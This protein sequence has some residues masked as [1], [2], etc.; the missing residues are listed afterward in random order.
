M[1]ASEFSN[2]LLAVLASE[3][4]L[5]DWLA[6]LRDALGRRPLSAADALLIGVVLAKSRSVE[7]VETVLEV[8][9]V[10]K[11]AI[12]RKM[13][14][15]IALR[16]AASLAV[17]LVAS[18]SKKEKPAKKRAKTKAMAGKDDARLS[19]YVRDALPALVAALLSFRSPK[20][21]ALAEESI[22]F[23]V[24]A[25]P[26][27]SP[28]A[29]DSCDIVDAHV[30]DVVMP[31][32]ESLM[33][34]SL[35]A[36]RTSTEKIHE[37]E[38]TT[39]GESRHAGDGVA[40]HVFATALRSIPEATLAMDG[41]WRLLLDSLP[42]RYGGH[43][44][45]FDVDP[46]LSAAG[47]ALARA[48]CVDD[49]RR[50]E[51]CGVIEQKLKGVTASRAV[52]LDVL[53][54]MLNG[55]EQPLSQEDVRLAVRW[56]LHAASSAKVSADTG[57]MSA[58]RLI[59]PAAAVVIAAL[60]YLER[61]D[62]AAMRDGWLTP[63]L[64]AQALTW[65]DG[66]TASGFPPVCTVRSHMSIPIEERLPV[67]AIAALFHADLVLAAY[68]NPME[69]R[70]RV[71]NGG[72]ELGVASLGRKVNANEKAQAGV[73]ASCTNEK[74]GYLMGA[75]AMTVLAN[76]L[77]AC[78]DATQIYDGDNAP[79]FFDL[80]LP[81]AD[82]R[83]ALLHR[84]SHL[85]ALQRGIQ[86][87][88]DA[89]IDDAFATAASSLPRVQV[90][91]WLSAVE[92]VLAE[93]GPQTSGYSRFDV[94]DVEPQVQAGILSRAAAA[95]STSTGLTK[96]EAGHVSTIAFDPGFILRE[97]VRRGILHKSLIL[98]ERLAPNVS[99]TSATAAMTVQ[100]FRGAQ[101]DRY[102]ML[103]ERLAAPPSANSHGEGNEL[104]IVKPSF[105]RWTDTS[106]SI[107]AA[108]V[109][110]CFELCTIAAMSSSSPAI[111]ASV[112]SALA[113]PVLQLDSWDLNNADGLAITFGAQDSAQD[114]MAS[115]MA[116]HTR[117]AVLQWVTARATE[118][119]A[120]RAAAP[121][122]S[123]GATLLLG[124]PRASV[125]ACCP[126]L[127]TAHASA[128]LW[129]R[130]DL[131]T[132]QSDSFEC[133]SLQ[134]TRDLLQGYVECAVDDM[135]LSE[136]QCATDFS[137]G[138]SFERA[139]RVS[140]LKTAHHLTL[141]CDGV[142]AAIA[143]I[144]DV[145]HV[146]SNTTDPMPLQ[147]SSTAISVVLDL[148]TSHVGRI[149]KDVRDDALGLNQ[150][151]REVNIDV[152]DLLMR[153]GE[154]IV[155]TI[156]A[157]AM[158]VNNESGKKR[159]LSAVVLVD[160]IHGVSATL[161]SLISISVWIASV[162]SGDN[163]KS[164]R[165]DDVA[166]AAY[167][168]SGRLGIA[169][170]SLEGE[171]SNASVKR[172]SARMRSNR[173]S[174]RAATALRAGAQLTDLSEDKNAAKTGRRHRKFRKMRWVDMEAEEPSSDEGGVEGEADDD[175]DDAIFCVRPNGDGIEG[176]EM[177]HR[178]SEK[179]PFPEVDGPVETETTAVIVPQIRRVN[180]SPKK[181]AHGQD[182]QVREA[183]NNLA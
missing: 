168:S 97:L 157:A 98:A 25:A 8:E 179:R 9:R 79:S 94:P 164:R 41:P 74:W 173:V 51:L 68:V 162:R 36:L 174:L 176:W 32:L 89:E 126:T 133:R 24:A 62:I 37:T 29:I 72:L 159:K 155:Q 183:A 160:I 93:D 146:I 21:W 17:E 145:V 119:T 152:S 151:D 175:E 180:A 128:A 136:P 150:R 3:E 10:L 113:A 40:A 111:E 18:H 100:S 178:Q 4:R 141:K 153:V 60:P 96:H 108:I 64:S 5:R 95:F 35:S 39:K 131:D 90:S 107:R 144:M 54:V 177:H 137:D 171:G 170:D 163:K 135:I 1:P 2:E 118:C 49:A 129:G 82:V 13:L 44:D 73:A 7:H 31:I 112:I 42:V 120:L 55:P 52:G 80:G 15:P 53:R 127:V 130:T 86:I 77:H 122:L 92:A 28:D 65:R 156:D 61:D 34:S 102:Q 46:L 110:G 117:L 75:A 88:V 81:T 38:A 12:A 161:L 11:R 139:Q 124:L 26:S 147:S 70:T 76:L 71:V 105:G 16:E 63:R 167:E 148:L 84:L 181:K 101:P 78:L 138:T 57:A 69:F 143:V 47:R 123:L 50:I 149:I 45:S 169:V 23:L 59:I 6:S 140:L 99:E 125:T 19:L 85:L 182:V 166:K 142:N 172:E 20:A 114:D 30:R 14:D 58:Q 91:T 103:S 43:V 165:L 116:S 158:L 106:A 134:L 67:D 83:R 87:E 109:A 121:A 104:V 154:L 66:T 132:S 22:P 33:R 27:S 115:D 48:A 56:A